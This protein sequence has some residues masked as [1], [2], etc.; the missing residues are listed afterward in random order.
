M[1]TIPFLKVN[2]KKLICLIIRAL[3]SNYAYFRRLKKGVP[4][5][6]FFAVTGALRNKGGGGWILS[7]LSTKEEIP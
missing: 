3:V 6:V 1:K 7:K 4:S 5:S 2:Q